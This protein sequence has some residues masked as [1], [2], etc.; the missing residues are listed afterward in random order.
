VTVPAAN[1]NSAE[2]DL[3]ALACATR[4]VYREA[5]AATLRA[6]A[7]VVGLVAELQLPVRRRRGRLSCPALDQALAQAW[8]PAQ[9]EDAM[10]G[11][12]GFPWR[13]V[14]LA[15]W[16]LHAAGLGAAE[17]EQ[18]AAAKLRGESNQLAELGLVAASLWPDAG[19]AP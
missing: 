10:A 14:A 3:A 11:H 16:R 6:A 9:V 8:S 2:R 12:P 13:I 19:G 1:A 4:D 17:L 15:L 18:L 5:D 7:L